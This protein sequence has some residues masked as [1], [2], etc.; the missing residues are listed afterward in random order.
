VLVLLAASGLIFW[1]AKGVHFEA[2]ASSSKGIFHS[3]AAMAPAI[4]PILWTYGGW[5]QST[6]MSGEF[7][8]TKKA[9]PLSLITGVFL[10]TGVYV[11][12]NAAYLRA[13]SPEQ[14]IQSRA[15]AADIFKDLFGPAGRTLM[16]AAVL[17][18]ASGALNST[19]LTGGRIPFA[20]AC[21]YPR[22]S[23]FAKVDPRFETPL[24]SLIVNGI[25]ASILVLWGNFEQLLFFFAFANWFF[26]ALVGISVFVFRRQIPQASNFCMPG[27]PMVPILFILSSVWVCWITIQHAP[28]ETFVGVILMLMGI[29]VYFLFRKRERACE[30]FEI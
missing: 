20:V 11:L 16:T 19:I 3:A 13:M 21:D 29:P 7:Q 6:F 2:A 26:F 15:I 28:Y 14:M 18:S 17:I 8:D 30:K 25:W 4:I 5:H 10:V 24:R 1:L 27:Y 9:L 22:L 12:I 23:W